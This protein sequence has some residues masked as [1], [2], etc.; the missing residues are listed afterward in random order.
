MTK[1]YSFATCSVLALIALGGLIYIHGR[2]ID[3][4][5]ALEAQRSAAAR[6]PR[7][8]AEQERLQALQVSA[9]RLEALRR[10]HAEIARWQRQI[11]S[12]SASAPARPEI[13]ATSPA[14]AR[15]ISNTPLTAAEWKN[16]G[17]AT[18][19]A[20]YET[21]LWAAAAGDLDTLAHSFALGDGGRAM[22][23][24]TFAALPDTTRA[25]MGSPDRL[26]AILIAKEPLPQATQVLDSMPA[27]SD[28]ASLNVSLAR[29]GSTPKHGVYNLRRTGNEWQMVV[30]DVLIMVLSADVLGSGPH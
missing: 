25:Q 11:Q 8:R 9:E 18:P 20:A 13:A 30:P 1:V 26:L 3:L 7:A 2:S 14:T 28:Q 27:E 19:V 29:D 16:V 5:A 6:L 22:L 4:Q 24:R 15:D 10:D 23:E 17:R 21:I 12:L